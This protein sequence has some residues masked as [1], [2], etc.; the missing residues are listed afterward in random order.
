V[1][2]IGLVAAGD[3]G[4]ALGRVLSDHSAEV[5]TLLEGRSAATRERAENARMQGVGEEELVAADVILSVLPPGQAKAFAERIAPVLARS[6]RKPPYVECNPV[7]PDEVRA[8]EAIIAP[9]GAPF[10][11][12]GIIGLT[13]RPGYPGPVIYVSGTNAPAVEA[14]TTR[15]LR[16][17]VLDA[18]VGAASALKLS[19]AGITKGL[20]ALASATI[21][22]A[23]REHIAD[24]LYAELAESQPAIMAFIG[25]GIPDMFDKTGRWVAEMEAIGAYVGGEGR[26]EGDLYGNIAAFYSRMTADHEGAGKE[27]G[28]LA[29]F[30]AGNGKA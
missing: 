23:G 13:P 14:L 21:L 8:I 9:T 2:I 4:A 20:F 29:A 6:G 24:T 17:R 5:R 1:K 10:V 3:M 12:G 19:Y 30:F 22:G 18:P 11:D 15:G 26:V 25:R 27:T 7:S 16:I 28:A